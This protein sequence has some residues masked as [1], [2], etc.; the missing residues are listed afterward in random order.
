MLEAA[1]VHT[2]ALVAGGPMLTAPTA[3]A[4]ASV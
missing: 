1:R 3:A 4:T 2:R